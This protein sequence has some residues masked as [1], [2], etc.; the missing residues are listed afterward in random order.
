MTKLYVFGLEFL[1]LGVLAN[2]VAHYVIKRLEAPP[3]A[4]AAGAET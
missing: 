1:I 3:N 2:I 4:D